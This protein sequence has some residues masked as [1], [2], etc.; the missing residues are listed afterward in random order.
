M[1]AAST[2]GVSTPV[3]KDVRVDRECRLLEAHLAK[4]DD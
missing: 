3:D 2:F 4:R 1:K